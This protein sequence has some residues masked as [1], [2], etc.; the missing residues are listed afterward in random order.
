LLVK[1]IRTPTESPWEW[2]DLAAE[3]LADRQFRVDT[4]PYEEAGS[5][6]RWWYE[7]GRVE[8]LAY[9]IDRA[10]KRGPVVLIGHSY[11]CRLG[12][13]AAVAAKS[14]P[15]ELHLV[16]GAHSADSQASGLNEYLRRD[17]LARAYVYRGGAD[18]VLKK[19]T[20]VSRVVRPLAKAV[21]FM[22]RVVTLGYSKPTWQDR[23]GYGDGGYPQPTSNYNLDPTVARRVWF[24][25]RPTFH[26]SEFLD[27]DNLEGL[28]SL[29]TGVSG[30][31]L[32]VDEVNAGAA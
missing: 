10:A 14:P 19:L 9:Q 29:V 25:D 30:F 4:L 18:M 20:P 23:V 8:A 27:G 7:P 5:I 32:T 6:L 28:L 3:W 15:M 26:H 22:G 21:A 12:L 11:G 16:S 2:D 17:P 13:L 24:R 1:G 31:P